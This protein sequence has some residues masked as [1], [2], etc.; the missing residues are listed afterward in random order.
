M[1][2]PN[3]ISFRPNRLKETAKFVAFYWLLQAFLYTATLGAILGYESL[4]ELLP[5]IF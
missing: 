5:A 3:A 2:T 4:H 1:N